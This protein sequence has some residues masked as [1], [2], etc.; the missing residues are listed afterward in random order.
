MTNVLSPFRGP[1]YAA[2][3]V[4]LGF[5]YLSHGLAWI[6]GIWGNR[7]DFGTW[8]FFYAGVVEIICGPL[9][10]VGWLTPLAAFIA[11]GEMAAAYWIAHYPRGQG[12][13]PILNGSEITVALCFGFLYIATNG[14]GAFSIDWL[15]GRK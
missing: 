3:R 13:A 9:I 11:S 8:P 6:F 10:I 1:A 7:A 4:V 15:R 14:G 12:W 5:L 2:M